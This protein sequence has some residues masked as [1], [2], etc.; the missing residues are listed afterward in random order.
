MADWPD[1]LQEAL[2]NIG[3]LRGSAGVGRA[4]GGGWLESLT[5]SPDL[6]PI[7]A[8]FVWDPCT[9]STHVQV[10]HY[11]WRNGHR[12]SRCCPKWP[13]RAPAG[14]KSVTQTPVCI[15]S[16]VRSS[17][18]TA[19]YY[20]GRSPVFLLLLHLSRGS[21][22]ADNCLILPSQIYIRAVCIS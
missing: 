1:A 15:D 7:T 17:F 14:K 19:S 18:F 9:L 20:C 3:A 22:G 10:W 5:H 13:W 6:L 21:G 4:G 2:W 12:F 11:N 8:F 16:W